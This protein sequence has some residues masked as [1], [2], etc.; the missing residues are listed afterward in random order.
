MP[1]YL[2]AIR[3]VIFKSNPD[4]H[5]VSY[6]KRAREISLHGREDVAVWQ[7]MFNAVYGEETDCIEMLRKQVHSYIMNRGMN[8][9]DFRFQYSFSEFKNGQGSLYLCST[10]GKEHEV[11][12]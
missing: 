10:L 7:G 11:V 4:K 9:E 12:K 1:T 3:R 2:M 5:T 6:D 8:P